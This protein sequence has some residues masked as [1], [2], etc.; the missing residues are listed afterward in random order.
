MITQ[1]AERFYALKNL[2]IEK[3][4]QRRRP[5]LTPEQVKL[6]S[7]Q[8]YEDIQAGQYQVKTIA[9]A[10]TVWRVAKDIPAPEPEPKPKPKESV[11]QEL[12]QQAVRLARRLH[13]EQKEHQRKDSFLW[14]LIWVAYLTTGLS[15]ILAGILAWRVFV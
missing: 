1:E 6:A 2:Q 15:T 5:I 10:H 11:N 4:I 8:V 3:L 14:R 9:L 7:Q 13:D 12:K